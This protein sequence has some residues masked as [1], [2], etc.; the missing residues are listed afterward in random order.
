M[1]TLTECVVETVNASSEEIRSA[2]IAV[3]NEID[4]SNAVVPRSVLR[5]LLAETVEVE[6]EQAFG[7]VVPSVSDTV[8]VSDAAV[9]ATARLFA[10]TVSVSDAVSPGNTTTQLLSNTINAQGFATPLPGGDVADTINVSDAVTLGVSLATNVSETAYASAAVSFAVGN[11]TR[12]VTVTAYASSA[13]EIQVRRVVE[14]EAVF[15][16]SDATS[17]A[18]PGLLA[19][20]MNTETTAMS[21]FTDY[22][23]N[24]IAQLGDTILMAGPDGL[25]TMDASVGVSATLVTGFYDFG[26]PEYKRISDVYFTYTSTG[27]IAVSL[28]AYGPTPRLSRDHTSQSRAAS[29]PRVGRVVGPKGLTSNYWRLTFENIEGGRFNMGRIEANVAVSK[30]RI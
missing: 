27:S 15:Y 22:G 23:Y 7:F 29:A 24:S 3:T 1:P 10:D 13:T 8:N 19:W 9:S 17:F 25:Y 5:R 28:E 16:A 26:V 2:Y 18:N 11:N 4:A 20:V 6:D 21:R 14:V 12:S 30:R